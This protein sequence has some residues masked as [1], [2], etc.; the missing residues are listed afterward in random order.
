MITIRVLYF[1]I[2]LSLFLA[3]LLIAGIYYYFRERRAQK[4]PYGKWEDILKRLTIVN[5]DSS[6]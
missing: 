4:Y 3:I 5:R 6:E 1:V 2:A